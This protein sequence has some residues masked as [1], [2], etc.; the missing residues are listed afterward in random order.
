MIHLSP[1][2]IVIE[3]MILHIYSLGRRRTKEEERKSIYP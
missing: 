1:R 3:I 2:V